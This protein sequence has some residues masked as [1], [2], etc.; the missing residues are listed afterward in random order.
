MDRLQQKCFAASAGVHSLLMVILVV[1]PAF[2]V[3]TSKPDNRPPLDVIPTKV[4]DGIFSGGGNPNGTPPPPAPPVPPAPPTPTPKPAPEPVKQQEP[5]PPPTPVKPQA[6]DPNT[7]ETKTDKKPRLPDVST[8]PV[9]R[10][11]DTK[12]QQDTTST[13]SA[14][15]KEAQR[16]AERNQRIAAALGASARSLRADMKPGTSIEAFGPGGG[17][18]V[19]AGYDQVVQSVYWHAWTPPDDTAS[20]SAIVKASVVIAS[21][22]TV[23]SARIIQSSSDASVNRSVQRTLENVTF[24]HAFP[25]GA[26]EKQ[27]TYT[28]KF[29]LKAKRLS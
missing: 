10:K 27:R 24:I 15:Q 20:D 2:L 3:P 22:G 6:V 13:T 25:E 29:D 18:E 11:R 1:G 7:L 4:I 26:K 21:D 12:K 8:T 28:I 9:V 5:Q 23:M 16:I 14:E 17:G 19:Y